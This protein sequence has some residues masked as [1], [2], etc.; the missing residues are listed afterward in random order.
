M[1]H[2]VTSNGHAVVYRK[3]ARELPILD[4]G[5]PVSALP[6]DLLLR[7]FSFLDV[8]S[9]CRAAQ[10]SRRWHD[11]ALHGSNWQRVDLFEFQMAIEGYV[12]EQMSRRCG[13]FLRTLSL[14][15]CQT[16]GD[17]ALEKF[18]HNCPHME[19]LIL[20]KCVRITDQSAESLSRSC[21]NL[22][23]LNL[24]SCRAIT[25]ET[26]RHLGEGCHKLEHIDLSYCS[27]S[28]EGIEQ[29][30]KGCPGLRHV[31]LTYCREVM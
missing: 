20:S 6:Q 31:I 12:V 7:I 16:V 27:V 28:V 29:L 15:D 22:L 1:A 2:R 24:S 23:Y 14:R 21:P 4:G 25:N 18:C 9:L 13:G 30:V 5:C 17:T 3:H 19:K 8:V 10:V 26:C 11:L